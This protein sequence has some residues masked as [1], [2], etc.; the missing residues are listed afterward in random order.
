MSDKTFVSVAA[1]ADR[2]GV[3]P[4]TIRRL[5]AAGNLTG[6]RLG[7]RLIRIDL[8]ELDALLTPINTATSSRATQ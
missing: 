5:I 7:K 2:I 6:Y 3:A 4:L 1:A 8:D